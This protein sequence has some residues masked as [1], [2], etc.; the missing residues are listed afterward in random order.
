MPFLACHVLTSCLYG[1]RDSGS[2]LVCIPILLFFIVNFIIHLSKLDVYQYLT[3]V[4]VKTTITD[5]LVSEV[6]H[7]A[8]INYMLIL[9][10]AWTTSFLNV[11]HDSGP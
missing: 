4:Q 6:C 9:L 8:Q 10:I 3:D 11:C 7:T 1:H 5:D 2:T